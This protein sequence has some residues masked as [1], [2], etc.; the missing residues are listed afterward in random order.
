VRISLDLP[1]YMPCAH[2]ILQ[3][4]ECGMKYSQPVCAIVTGLLHKGLHCHRSF[5]YCSFRSE[6]AVC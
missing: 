3:A 2:P 5:I 1:P 4:L 6:V